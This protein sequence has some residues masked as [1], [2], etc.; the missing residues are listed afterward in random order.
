MIKKMFVLATMLISTLGCAQKEETTFKNESL[1]YVLKTTEDKPISFQEIV[2]K[3]EGK[4]IFIE[5]WASWCSDCI[6]AMPEVKKLNQTYGK[7]VVFVNLSFDKTS[8]KWIQG[9]EKHEV[10]GENYFIGDNMKGT[11]GKSLDVDW[12]PRYLIVD[13]TGNIVLYRAI[14][15]DFDKIKEVLNKVK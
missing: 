14:E 13:K 7:D 4:T 9:I 10:E 12:I 2:K 11:F 1:N 3:H 5:L 15:K 6:K 8:E